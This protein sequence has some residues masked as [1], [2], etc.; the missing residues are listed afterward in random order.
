MAT[1]NSHRKRQTYSRDASRNYRGYSASGTAT[2]S[3]VTMMPSKGTSGDTYSVYRREFADLTF[4][5]KASYV[6]STL[7]T[8]SIRTPN[9][10]GI[11][12]HYTYLDTIRTTPAGMMNPDDP[13]SGARYAANHFGSAAGL[14]RYDPIYV[15]EMSGIASYMEYSRRNTGLIN[16]GHM[17]YKSVRGGNTNTTH[18]RVISLGDYI[19]G[20]IKSRQTALKWIGGMWREKK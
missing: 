10:S 8:E 17:M 7:R 4:K 11:G 3:A 14:M 15:A 6:G 9:T 2:T 5:L 18:M 1:I 13:Y 16:N 19:G 12:S 20:N